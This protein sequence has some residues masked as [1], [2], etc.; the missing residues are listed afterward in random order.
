MSNVKISGVVITFN[1]ES[2]IQR[3]ITSMQ[4]VVDEVLVVDSFSTDKTE[5]ICRGLGVK[6]MQNKFS[7]H[8]EQKN[9]AV[10][11]AQ[12][13]VVLSLDADECL[14]EELQQAIIRA[15]S[16]GL[17]N[18]YSMNRLTS[19]CGKWIHHSGWYPDTK[20]R[21]WDRTIGMWKGE[22]PHDRVVLNSGLKPKHLKGDILHYSFPTIRSHVET[23][24]TFSEIA[25]D[26]AIRKGRKINIIVHIILNPVWTFFNRY[27]FRLGF[28]DGLRGFVISVLSAYS[29]FLKYT[30]IWFKSRSHGKG[31]DQ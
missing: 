2:N 19:Y 5:E 8:I 17:T 4:D 25:A 7:G 3:C 11:Q 29:N 14:S 26:A 1:E 16:E 30:K 24:N 31:P 13:N 23:A 20:I 6:F 18:A 15:K 22:N 28:L 9:F 12:N 10:E 27:I 21:L